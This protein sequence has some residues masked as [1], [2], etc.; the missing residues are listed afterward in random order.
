MSSARCPVLARTARRDATAAAG[1][2]LGRR[3]TRNR[4]AAAIP[5]HGEKEVPPRATPPHHFLSGPVSV[6]MRA[7]TEELPARPRP[8]AAL[9]GRREAPVA[10]AEG[11]PRK[12]DDVNGL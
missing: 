4:P 2:A 3:G 8:D 5:W 10:G 9:G 12:E 1:G 11:T 7:A 6:R